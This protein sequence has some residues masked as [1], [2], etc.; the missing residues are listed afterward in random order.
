MPTSGFQDEPYQSQSAFLGFKLYQNVSTNKV[1]VLLNGQGAD[2]YLGGYGQFTTA[3]Y[4]DMIRYMRFSELILDLKNSNDLNTFSIART[5][6]GVARHLLPYNIVRTLTKF[7]NS[8]DYIRNIVNIKRL[9]VFFC[10]PYDQIPV[11]YRT[12]S[13]I[14]DH[15]LFYSTLPKYLRWEDRNSM[16]NSVEARSPYLDHR[17]VEFAYNLPHNFLEKDGVNKR[18][19]RESFKSIIPEQ[20]K[21]RKDKMGFITP[22]EM[23]VRKENPTLFRNKLKEAIELTDG[24]IKPRALDY[25]DGVVDGK[26]KFDYTYWRLILFGLWINKFNIKLP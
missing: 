17:L 5:I 11:P 23:W 19:M 2:E 24:I 18:I 15:L 3:R 21:N 26:Y 8:S 10:H 6:S 13:D 9:N 16:A 22:E 14:S 4:A 1:K 20:I 7:R 12:V 25:F